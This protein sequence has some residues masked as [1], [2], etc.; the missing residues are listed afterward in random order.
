MNGAMPNWNA[1]IP[2]KINPCEVTEI[3]APIDYPSKIDYTI[4]TM[5]I[6]EYFSLFENKPA[7]GE[8]MI[9]Q[10]NF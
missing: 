4:G 7:C 1:N 9:Y 6:S 10:I 2:I 8:L 3:V 5:Q